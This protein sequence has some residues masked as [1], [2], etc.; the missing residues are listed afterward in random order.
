[1]S[2]TKTQPTDASVQAF[3]DTV[4]EAKRQDSRML[5]TLMRQAS[6]HEPVLWGTNIIGFGTYRYHYASGRQGD[7]MKIGF[8]PRKAAF[9]L[10]LSCDLELLKDEL[11]TLGMFTH[12]KGCIYI[13]RLRDVETWRRLSESLQKHM[14]SPERQHKQSLRTC[15][16]PCS[17]ARH[18]ATLHVAAVADGRGRQR[19]TNSSPSATATPRANLL[20]SFS[21]V[22][23]VRA[24]IRWFFRTPVR[25]LR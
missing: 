13:K 18:E 19:S 7:W 10:Y 15:L 2:D 16:V 6:D 5:I 14:R 12:G 24:R 3:L 1:M 23:F 25:R 8:S 4:D 11:A 17:G 9:S 20:R 22:Q 21:A